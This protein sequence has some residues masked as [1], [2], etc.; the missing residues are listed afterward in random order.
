MYNL[1]RRKESIVPHIIAVIILILLLTLVFACQAREINRVVDGQGNIYTL[2][3]KGNQ[4]ISSK[5]GKP[6]RVIYI[7]KS[8]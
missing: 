7:K 8:R 1:N 3:K 2:T 5:N 6:Y 4:L